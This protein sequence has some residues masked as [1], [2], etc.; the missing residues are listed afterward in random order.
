MVI[1]TLA[2]FYSLLLT[3][4]A[5]GLPTRFDHG[6]P[7][8]LAVPREHRSLLGTDACVR[9]PGGDRITYH[10]EDICPACRVGTVDLLV[11]STSR[12]RS[13]GRMPVTVITGACRG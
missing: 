8:I 12:A 3:L 2:T 10:V 9:F 5:T 7:R 13:L 1:A 4:T 6:N 11:S